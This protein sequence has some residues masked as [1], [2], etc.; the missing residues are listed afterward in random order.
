MSNV[1]VFRNVHS[2]LTKHGYRNEI[3]PYAIGNSASSTPFTPRGMMSHYT[4]SPFTTDKLLF[5]EGNGRVPGPLA[6]WTIEPDG[7][8]KGGATEYTNNAGYGDDWLL[9][10][11]SDHDV[12]ILGEIDPG[13]DTSVSL[14]R[15]VWACETK[16]YSIKTPEQYK[17]ECALWAAVT[18]AQGWDADA[19]RDGN[20]VPL[21]GHREAT[22]RKID[23][24][25]NMFFMRTAV[26]KLVAEWRGGITLPVAE[27]LGAK[28]PS[29]I[30]P[31]F[32]LGKCRI[33]EK[34]MYF[35]EK[36]GPDHEVSGY[37]QRKPD[38]SRGHIGLQTFQKQMIHR[39][40]VSIGAPDGQYG[41]LTERVV[42]LFQAQKGLA[43]DG[44][45]GPLTW[46]KAW[47][48]PITN[49]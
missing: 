16:A 42:R 18:I 10:E 22:D 48:Y 8:I 14:N 38:G 47:T 40:W 19:D 35:G 45:I 27:P 44:K 49:D 25:E 32:P 21:I 1:D 39:G 26:A 37:Y 6:H 20:F 41:D 23:P 29:A 17:N 13:P 46:N 36:K 12:D 28:I 31:A 43:V 2:L 24:I 4:A 3:L 34:Q 15:H 30:P 11:L 33:H 5:I 7:F 9:S